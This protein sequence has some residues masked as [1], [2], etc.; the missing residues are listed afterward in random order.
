MFQKKK[1]EKN[2][3]NRGKCNYN[4]KKKKEYNKNYWKK[5][6]DKNKNYWKKKNIIIHYKMKQ[7]IVVK[8]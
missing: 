6:K 4:Q 3:N 5:K 1:R 2:Y 7:K 8:L